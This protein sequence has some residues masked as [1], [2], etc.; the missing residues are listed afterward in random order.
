MVGQAGSCLRDFILHEAF[1]DAE[2]GPDLCVRQV[3]QAGKDKDVAHS[4]WQS[5]QGPDDEVKLL[6]PFKK[7]IRSKVFVPMQTR[8]EIGWGVGF[9]DLS[10]PEM[11]HG[12]VR[13]HTEKIALDPT[14]ACANIWSREALENLL[15]GVLRIGKVHAAPAEIAKQHGLI[16]PG[17]L[18]NRPVRLQL[19]R[20]RL[21]GARQPQSSLSEQ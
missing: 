15:R 17:K 3:F 11:F 20:S 8:C 10:I 12:D 2:P 4:L 14:N 7:P 5:I 16:S 9:A 18:V 19:V 6:T 1:G 21:L 13:G